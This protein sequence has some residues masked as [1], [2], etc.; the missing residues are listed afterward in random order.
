MFRGNVTGFISS[1]TFELYVLRN[2]LSVNPIPERAGT[3]RAQ[4]IEEG[5]LCAIQIPVYTDTDGFLDAI[6]SSVTTSASASNQ[7]NIT[8]C[9]S[10]VCHACTENVT[11]GENICEPCSSSA[12]CDGIENV[13]EYRYCDCDAVAT[14]NDSNEFVLYTVSYKEMDDVANDIKVRITSETT[15]HGLLHYFKMVTIISHVY[16][17][18]HFKLIGIFN[19]STEEDQDLSITDHYGLTINR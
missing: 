1:E 4:A 17:L 16:S 6:V 2:D 12:D 3:M 13:V 14:I 5:G 8:V 10:E 18:D 19:Q 7:C 9:R 11:Q 15:L